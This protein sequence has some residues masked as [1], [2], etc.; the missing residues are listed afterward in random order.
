VD[1]ATISDARPKGRPRLEVT[2]LSSED[3]SRI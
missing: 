2:P 3:V 1:T